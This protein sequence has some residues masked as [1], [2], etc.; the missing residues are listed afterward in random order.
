M[1]TT[2]CSLRV[3]PQLIRAT[4]PESAQ[5][6]WRC[7]RGARQESAFTKNIFSAENES[8]FSEFLRASPRNFRS[9]ARESSGVAAIAHDLKELA[10]TREL[11]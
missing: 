6:L 5:H 4:L 1:P 2:L 8:A 11:P 7:Q 10:P 9:T 3:C